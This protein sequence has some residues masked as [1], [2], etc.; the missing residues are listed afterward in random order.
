MNNTNSTSLNL[1]PTEA[2]ALISSVQLAS[3]ITD[4]E[5]IQKD[6]V[7]AAKKIQESLGKDSEIF[8]FLELGWKR[9]EGG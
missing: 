2:L 1:T 9:I 7:M 8:K 5:L 3:T 4:T 6:A